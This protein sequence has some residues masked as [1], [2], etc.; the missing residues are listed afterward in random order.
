MDYVG[1]KIKQLRLQNGLTITALSE[2]S[3]IAKSYIS[4]IERNIQSNPSINCLTKIA[5][6]LSVPVHELIDGI[7]EY[8]ERKM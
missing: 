3:G 5:D 8:A 7:H 4:S 2:R 1:E 6:A